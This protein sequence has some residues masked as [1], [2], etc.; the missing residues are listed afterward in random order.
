[1]HTKRDELKSEGRLRDVIVP[2]V[3]ACAAYSAFRMIQ[4]ALLARVDPPWRGTGVDRIMLSAF[5]GIVLAAAVPFAVWASRRFPVNRTHLR[6]VGVHLIFGLIYA[7]LWMQAML[8]AGQWLTGLEAQMRF[9]RYYISWVPG[10]LAAY[11][12]IVALTNAILATRRAHAEELRAS[13]L[14]GQLA[15]ARLETLKAQLQPHFL[16]NTLHTVSELVHINPAEADAMITSLGHLLRRT[17]D[18]SMM[19]E[20]TVADEIDYIRAYLDIHRMRHKDRL[21]ILFDIDHSVLAARVP[22][23]ILQ[24]LVENALRHGIAP[25]TAGGTITIAARADGEQLKLSVI[26][27]G[28]GTNGPTREGI[29]IG[30]TRKRLAEQFGEAQSFALAP[31]SPRGAEATVRIPLR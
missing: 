19:H 11:T 22:P 2:M 6:N 16:F 17:L 1:V 5:D 21:N 10:G 3:G 20:V 26:D 18:A 7:A 24:P 4:T 27:D 12:V 14:D 13:R 8:R 9:D 28:A 29:G 25:S 23:L 30:N 31:H 15:A